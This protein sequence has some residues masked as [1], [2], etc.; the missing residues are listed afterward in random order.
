MLWS[1]ETKPAP[2]ICIFIYQ[3]DCIAFKTP[4]HYKWP[5]KSLQAGDFLGD[6]PSI[7]AGKEPQTE[8]ICTKDCE[9][10]EIKSTELLE[11]LRKNPGMKLAMREEYIIC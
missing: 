6:F 5:V 4:D 7:V 3:E 11:F 9:V 2:N 8:A 10:I 1:K